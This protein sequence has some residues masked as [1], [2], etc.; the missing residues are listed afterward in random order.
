M[1]RHTEQLRDEVAILAYR[2]GDVKG[3]EELISRWQ[4]R[5]YVYVST[6][7]GDREAA[8]DVAQEVW[9]AAVS[10][11][12]RRGNIA[13]FGA[14]LYGT[15]HNK[16]MSYLRARGALNG[17][18]YTVGAEAVPEG[19]ET[20][21]AETAFAAEDIQAVRKCIEELPVAQREALTLFYLDELSLNEVAGIVGAPVGT[22]QSRL[23]YGRLRLKEG[24]MRKG[25]RD[26]R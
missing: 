11:I 14:W 16:C 24:L 15:A 26:G 25:Y 5:I 21:P 12:R 19:G 20:K 3:L 18:G 17:A 13:C 7:I 10:G 22:V 4:R 23:H 6:T 8:W 2:A 1:E 9:M